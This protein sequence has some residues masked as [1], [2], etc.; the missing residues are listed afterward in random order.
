MRRG[1]LMLIFG[2][3]RGWVK[4]GTN[5]LNLITINIFSGIV[6]AGR[7]GCGSGVYSL[8]KLFFPMHKL[9]II[10]HTVLC[11]G[12][13]RKRHDTVRETGRNQR[14]IT[15]GYSTGFRGVDE[16]GGNR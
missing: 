15:L 11:N 14:H 4:F 16:T 3:Q 5:H 13:Q 10:S 8:V 12:N 2:K 1:Y 9:F 6:K 7:L